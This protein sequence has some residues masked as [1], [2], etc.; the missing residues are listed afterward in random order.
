MES[1]AG[2]KFAISG[3]CLVAQTVR[4]PF[5]KIGGR[6][7]ESTLGKSQNGNKEKRRNLKE[8]APWKRDM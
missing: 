4:A 5:F 6:W 2:G 3:G 1:P 8:K 7:F